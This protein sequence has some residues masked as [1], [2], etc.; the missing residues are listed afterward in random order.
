[1]AVIM[2]KL[3][4]KETNTTL[5]PDNTLSSLGK[6]ALNFMANIYCIKVFTQSEIAAYLPDK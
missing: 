4:V 5:L 1:M 2:S 3:M 6:M